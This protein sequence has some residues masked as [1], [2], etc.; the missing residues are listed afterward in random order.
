[1]KRR[2]SWRALGAVVAG[3][4][5]VIPL[6]QSQE[7]DRTALDLELGAEHSDNVGRVPVN[8]QSDTIGT[9][10]IALA[11]ERHRP[12]LEADIS[13]NLQYRRYFDDSFG[14]EVIGGADAYVGWLILPE[15]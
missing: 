5:L 2:T 15:R 1:M 9:A 11:L 3:S 4:A 8:E 10:S 14:D 12:K 13:G 7:S 6:A